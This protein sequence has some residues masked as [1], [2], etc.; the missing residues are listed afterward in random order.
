MEFT[1][2]TAQAVY[3][4]EKLALA[5]AE[6][7]P[8][9]WDCH[10]GPH[11]LRLSGLAAA[12][13][14]TDLPAEAGIALTL[15]LPPAE[16]RRQ[17]VAA[18]AQQHRCALPPPP[19]G[20]KECSVPTILAAF[21]FPGVNLYVFAEDATAVFRAAGPGQASVEI[22]GGFRAKKFP[23]READIL[24]HLEPAQAAGVLAFLLGLA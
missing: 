5:A 23:V 18:F 11:I 10:D 4:P 14:G 7:Q 6:P 12:P 1:C 16:A 17:A 2:E 21:R 13:E 8:L 19:A 3:P 22:R 15:A 24:I 20:A 9:I